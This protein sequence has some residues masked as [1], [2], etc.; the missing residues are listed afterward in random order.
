MNT[1][2][3][4]EPGADLSPLYTAACLGDYGGLADARAESAIAEFVAVINDRLEYN[5]VPV[6]EFWWRLVARGSSKRTDAERATAALVEAGCSELVVDQAAITISGRLTDVRI[7]FSSLYPKLQQQLPLR[8]RPLQEQWD[9]YGP[10][11]LKAIARRINDKL[12]PQRAR[13]E[14]VHP[15]SGGGGIPVPDEGWLAIEAV[16]TN[17]SLRVPEVLRLAW[18]IARLGLGRAEASRLVPQQR[19]GHTAA[20]ALLPIT[21]QAGADLGLVDAPES[22]LEE[23]LQLWRMHSVDADALFDWWQQTRQG[24]LPFPVALKALDR[25]LVA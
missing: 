9:A 17:P 13:I 25:M 18:L 2:L 11:L 3:Q 14:L 23:T 10:G 20:S 12:M 6:G 24:E 5:E 15:A 4:W 19:V 1:R 7:A 22:L 16:L 8:A 21:L